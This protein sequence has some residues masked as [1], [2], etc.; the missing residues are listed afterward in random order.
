MTVHYVTIFSLGVILII[1]SLSVCLL[2]YRGRSK[3]RSSKAD[4]LL[5]NNTDILKDLAGETNV[6][7]DEILNKFKDMDNIMHAEIIID[8]GAARSNTPISRLRKY[9][10]ATGVTDTYIDTL[11]HSSSWEKR[12]FAAEKLGQICSAK[13]VPYLL[14]IVMDT[15]NEDDDVRGAAL[16]A[17]GRIKDT[18]AIPA[19]VDAL[20][21]P[22]TWLPPR[23]SEILVSIGQETAPYLKKELKRSPNE[24][25]RGLA[26]EI[27]GCLQDKSSVM[28]LTDALSD[29]SPEVRAKAASALGKIKDSGAV[30]VMLELLI[31]DPIPFV[32]VRVAQALGSIGHPA[33]IDYLVNVLK[34]PEWWVRVR[35][36]E[37][38]EQFGEN[39]VSALLIALEDDD[40]E[41]RRRS[42]MALEK[43]G[44]VGKIIKEFRQEEYKPALKNILFLIARTG[45]IECISEK[46]NTDDVHLQK[47]IVRILGDAK[48]KDASGIL[49]ELLAN[50]TDWTFK[51][52]IIES[53][54]KIGTH[55]AVPTLIECLKDNEYWIRR[56]AVIALGMLG[57]VDSVDEIAE[58]LVDP[59]LHARE[60]AL[61]TLSSLKT[62]KYSRTIEACLDD[63]S[64]RVRG[65]ALRVMRELQISPDKKRVSK[66]LK[67][68]SQEV[69][70]EAVKYYAAIKDSAYLQEI[71]L[72]LPH[73]SDPLRHEIVEYVRT[74]RPKSFKKIITCINIDELSHEAIISL[75]EIASI[76]RDNDATRFILG[77]RQSMDSSIREQVFHEMPKLDFKG[78][79][80]I[81]EK[82]L[83][84]PSEKV[85][86]KVLTGIAAYPT[87]KLL[88]RAMILSKDPDEN[89]RAALVLVYG[90]S[91][92]GEFRSFIIAMLNDPSVRVI[93]AAF[94]SLASMNE[95]SL[96]GR[97]YAQEDIKEIKNEIRF[98]TEDTRFQYAVE[99]IRLQS[100][101]SSNLTVKLFLTADEKQF[102]NYLLKTLKEVFDPEIRLTALN[103]LK[104]IAT[105]D[106]FPVLLGIMKKDPSDEVRLLTMEMLG[107]MGREEET[108]SAI[109]SML[110]DP[111]LNV[112][113]RAAE[114]LGTYRHV[115]ALEVLLHTLDTTDR[116]FRE[117]VTTSLSNLLTKEPE[118]ISELIKGIP[119]TKTRKIGMAWLMGKS[120]KAGSMKYLINLM[121]DSDPD[122]RA[123]AIGAL[124]KFKRKNLLAKL[125][126]MIS[127]PNERVRA[128][129]VNAVTL[130]GGEKAFIILKNALEDIDAFV[131][132]RAAAGLAKLDIH[133]SIRVIQ[134]KANKFPDL[135]S[136]VRG[137]KFASGSPNIKLIDGDTLA[138]DVV[139]ELCP[140]HMMRKIFKQSS[141]KASRLLALRVLA[142]VYK[143]KSDQFIKK[144]QKDPSPEIRKE[145]KKIY[146]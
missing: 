78:Y 5:K 53:L 87:K 1:L 22:D 18:K 68:S 58:I 108:I 21:H 82:G 88:K 121:T 125:E 100:E 124:G 62:V 114:L 56:S 90:A 139:N 13:A 49:L 46:L 96:P 10:D 27:L 28:T 81:F 85:R 77:F 119:E 26:A 146:G 73:G 92:N 140:E 120:R 17:L 98:I 41:V 16:R 42:A 34:D 55:A 63:P 116:Q 80:A 135:R 132:I 20:G 113:I 107:S 111:A 44:Y 35:A 106:I 48:A 54:G 29:I 36:V 47:R 4:K 37:S 103:L 8:N 31:S 126:K 23:I 131:R 123:S 128:A 136:C 91:G 25:K 86:T 109:S 33:V 6:T 93:A 57:A 115:H 101:D 15:K 51:A 66:L 60:A 30:N 95:P 99:K 45:I 32:R 83:F 7:D 65:T 143:D 71:L 67:D 137:I 2:I 122:V 59:S 9:Y 3:L 84:D 110:V 24:T 97:L 39:A 94:I 64:S 74:A 104:I 69:R 112:R 79:H 130:I 105:G 117:A 14:S 141:D 43:I 102:V 11:Q 50:T 19:L 134:W 75:I 76:I 142:H 133:K 145:A 89:V 61:N 118:K 127:D 144:T 129:A 52:R 70:V 40:L 12:A 38:L 72:L 138:I